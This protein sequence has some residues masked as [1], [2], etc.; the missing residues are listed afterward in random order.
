[1]SGLTVFKRLIFF[2]GRFMYKKVGELIAA[3]ET[4]AALTDD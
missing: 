2:P 4:L 1:V 3:E